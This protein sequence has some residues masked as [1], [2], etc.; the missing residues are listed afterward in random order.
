MAEWIRVQVDPRVTSM[1]R[2]LGVTTDRVLGGLLQVWARFG[3]FGVHGEND[4]RPE[5]VDTV[6][7]QPGFSDA[8]EHAG[9]MA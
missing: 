1:A 7:G 2:R 9:W 5:Q 6:A 3:R 8:M 4:P